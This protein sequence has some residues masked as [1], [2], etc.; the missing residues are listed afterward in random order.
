MSFMKMLKSSGPKI[1]PFDKSK[2][3]DKSITITPNFDPLL[4]LTFDHP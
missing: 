3:F 2:A 4:S 1:K